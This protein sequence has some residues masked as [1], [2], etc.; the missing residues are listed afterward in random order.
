MSNVST[1]SLILTVSGL[2]DW[3]IPYMSFT[4]R[5]SSFLDITPSLKENDK[6][7]LTK[8]FSDQSVR[9]FRHLKHRLKKKFTP[10]SPQ[11]L[12]KPM[13]NFKIEK[14]WTS[15]CLKVFGMW[16]FHSYFYRGWKVTFVN[17]SPIA[18]SL[19]YRVYMA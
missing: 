17:L 15:F 5:A 1:I 3:I 6:N 19:C 18:L 12:Y 4:R 14:I 9:H 11:I 10:D 16:I 8:V 2:S 13:Q 7:Y